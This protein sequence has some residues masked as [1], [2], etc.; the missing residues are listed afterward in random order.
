MTKFRLAIIAAAFALLIGLAGY[1]WYSSLKG[2]ANGGRS[3]YT[4]QVDPS[5]TIGGPFTLTNQDGQRVDQSI[6]NG[7]WTAVF[8]GYTYCPD[9][10]PLTLQSLARTKAALGKDAD[11]LQIV[12]ITVDPERDSPANMKA[13]L[14]SGGFPPGVIGLT[15]TPEEIKSV[16]K[17][18]RVTA[19]KSGDGDNYTYNHTAVV[20]LMNPKGQFDSP[21]MSDITP[22]QSADQIKDSMKAKG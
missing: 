15:G 18:Y 13:Y 7:K 4:S 11:K 2:G 8:F 21:L 20:F 5:V 9:V 14:A 10:C 3:Q 12:F 1:N 22:Q 6:L 16:E 17:A 19:S